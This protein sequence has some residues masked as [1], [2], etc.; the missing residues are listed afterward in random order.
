M[1]IL[2][3]RYCF[4]FLLVSISVAGIAQN[5]ETFFEK[6]YG[7][8]ERSRQFA[9][10]ATNASNGDIV[11]TGWDDYLLSSAAE[12]LI[13]RFTEHGDPL[14]SKVI[15][16]NIG[17]IG[18]CIKENIDGGFVI[19]GFEEST[20]GS[21][22]AGVVVRTDSLGEVIWSKNIAS[23][24]TN[25]GVFDLAIDS[26]STIVVT[27]SQHTTLSVCKF[28]QQGNVIFSKN[29]TGGKR[30][31][32]ILPDGLGNYYVVGSARNGTTSYILKLSN[33][34]NIIWS[35]WSNQSGINIAKDIVF[36][37]NGNLLVTGYM[38]NSNYDAYLSIIDTSGSEVKSISLESG[39][40]EYGFSADQDS[41]GDIYLLS[42]TIGGAPQLSKYD[43][44]LNYKWGKRY[45]QH[46]STAGVGYST[47]VL[48]KSD[49][50]VLVGYNKNAPEHVSILK[51]DTNGFHPCLEEDKPI[52]STAITMGWYTYSLDSLW[53]YP[54]GVI[55]K[56]R[57]AYVLPQLDSTKCIFDSE[58]DTELTMMVTSCSSMS[59]PS[60]K[61]T[62]DSTGVYLDTIPNSVGCDSLI[63]IDFTLS[64]IDTSVVNWGDSLHCSQDR[65]SYQWLDCTNSFVPITGAIEQGFLP[66][67]KGNYAVEVTLDSCKDT[68]SCHWV[69]LA[70]IQ[71]GNF[72][73]LG[74]TYYP[75]PTSSNV[76]FQFNEITQ[77][78]FVEIIDNLGRGIESLQNSGSSKIE[79]SLPSGSGVYYVRI[80]CDNRVSVVKLIKL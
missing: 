8:T 13:S 75:N 35:K 7:P 36:M 64:P 42:G 52:T 16:S 31:S 28:D 22:R 79:I 26:D 53:P 9:Y 72:V 58:C 61:F 45:S 39:Y 70:S 6:I 66:D 50:I 69:D 73:S 57:K 74:F 62:I 20:N 60:G 48:V 71:G 51:I 12:I 55:D 41:L 49:Y 37:N 68:S 17:E 23:T 43:S 80:V 27:G 47:K 4:V 40:G 3:F 44:D 56:F 38:K 54:I 46:F 77:N 1:R 30:G 5:R 21:F 15:S 63:I 24:A 2:K 29:I 33:S 14:W 67:S 25:E 59:S 18:Y 10:N 76:I 34:G 11:I 19:G 78:V 32:K 65:A